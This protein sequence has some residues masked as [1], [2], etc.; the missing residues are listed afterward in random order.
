L[1]IIFIRYYKVPLPFYSS[2]TMNFIQINLTI[3]EIRY[4]VL[5][6]QLLHIYHCT[7]NLTIQDASGNIGSQFTYN[8]RLISLKRALLA[9]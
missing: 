3:A 4:L 5:W 6:W 8:A 9:P 2:I 1:K 7:L